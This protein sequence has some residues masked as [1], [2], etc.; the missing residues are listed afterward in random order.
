MTFFFF[1]TRGIERGIEEIDKSSFEKVRSDS[2]LFLK[3][4]IRLVERNWAGIEITHEN[5]LDWSKGIRQEL[6]EPKAFKRKS[7]FSPSHFNRSKN[8]LDWLN[9]NETKILKNSGKVFCKIIWK[10]IFMI[11]HECSW[12]QMIFKTKI[13][14]EKFK[15]IKFPHSLLFSHPK[16]ALNTSRNLNLVGHKT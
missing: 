7:H 9:F 15:F 8:K 16:N 6:K 1:L 10:T 2:L 11:W 4:K 13:Y 5:R 3:S 14:K 12:L